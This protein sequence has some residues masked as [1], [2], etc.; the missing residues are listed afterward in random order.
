MRQKYFAWHGEPMGKGPIHHED[1]PIEWE[2]DAFDEFTL[3]LWK[4]ACE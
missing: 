2:I 1:S 4:M 3:P